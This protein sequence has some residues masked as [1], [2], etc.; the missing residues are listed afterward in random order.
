MSRFFYFRLSGRATAA[1]GQKHAFVMEA[2]VINYGK[3]VVGNSLFKGPE[4]VV[5]GSHQ[6]GAVFG[7]VL[8]IASQG[9]VAIL[10]SQRVK[11]LN[12]GFDAG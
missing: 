4:K 6:K 7:R 12:Y 1:A 11:T 8:F 2:Y 5:G 9:R 10:F 3:T